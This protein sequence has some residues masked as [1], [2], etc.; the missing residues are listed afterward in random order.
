MLLFQKGNDFIVNFKCEPACG[1]HCTLTDNVLWKASFTW[2]CFLICWQMMESSGKASVTQSGT[3][4]SILSGDQVTADRWQFPGSMPHNHD[5]AGTTDSINWLFRGSFANFWGLDGVY[6]FEKP[7]AMLT[8]TSG[9]RVRI[10]LQTITFVK[11]VLSATG[12][13]NIEYFGVVSN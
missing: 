9:S 12:P 4:G 5:G 3:I 6:L 7:N 8:L 10:L 13:A 2:L 11:R 1:S